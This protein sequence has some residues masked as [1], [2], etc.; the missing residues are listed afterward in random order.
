MKKQFTLL[1]LALMSLSLLAYVVINKTTVPGEFKLE[2][3][4]EEGEK[5]QNKAQLAREAME[6][7]N[8]KLLD[9]NGQFHMAYLRDAI[10][11]ADEFKKSG[12]RAGALNL[13]WEELGPDNV[14]GR[15]RAILIDR[16]DPS[17]N[18]IYAGGVGGGMWKSTD[19][20]NTWNRLQGWNEW[21]TV[22]CIAQSSS[23]TIF[24]GTGEGLSNAG[25]TSFNSG[26]VGGGIF[27]LDASDNPV[28][29]SPDEY[30]VSNTLTNAD[31]FS[32]VNRIAE[33]GRAS[34]RERVLRLV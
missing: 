26:N 22:A 30:T 25:S 17:H 8:A 27:K 32:L 14:G 31:T 4:N 21:L 10:K 9:E 7:R 11:Q 20:A 24:I 29:I 3:M 6:W 15:T 19:G 34:C 16:R 2:E 1:F 13:Q 12:S 5:S 18:T 23:G 28:R 33:I